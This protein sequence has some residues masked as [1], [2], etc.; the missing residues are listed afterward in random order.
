LVAPTTPFAAPPIGQAAISI[1][2]REVS[3]RANAGMYTQPLSFIGLPVLSVPVV[4]PG[5]LPV[6]VQLIAAPWR[7]DLLLRIAAR[8]EDE[9]VIG[10]GPLPA[11]CE[12]AA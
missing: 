5:A 7:E 9:G 1:G 2:G 4:R 8:L 10:A 12:V 6:G 11:D 3:V